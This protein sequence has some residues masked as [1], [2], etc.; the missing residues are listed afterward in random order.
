MSLHEK[1]DVRKIAQRVIF[2]AVVG[3]MHQNLIAQFLI[4]SPNYT[5][6]QDFGTSV[7]SAAGNNITS[8][9][10]NLTGWS[11]DAPLTAELNIVAAAPTNAGGRYAYTLN[12]VSDRKIGARPSGG[13]GIVKYGILFQNTSGQTINSFSV[14]YSGFQF[15]LGGNTNAATNTLTVDYKVSVAT[16]PMNA[17]GA[18]PMPSLNYIQTQFVAVANNGSQGNG[19]PGAVGSGVNSGC[20]SVAA[21]IPD[22]SYLLLRWTDVDDPQN[23]PH[24]GIDNIEVVFFT[25][26]TVINNTA[27]SFL[28]IELLDFSGIKSGNENLLNW[29][30]A[31]E[32][33]IIYHSIEKS[34]NG[35][36]FI[37]IAKFT[38]TLKDGLVK[39]YSLTDDS[40]FNDI[41]YYRLSTKEKDGS[42]K[43]YKTVSVETKAANNWNYKHYVNE[44]SLTVEFKNDVPPNGSIEL[45]DVSGKL[46]FTEKITESKTNISISLLNEGIYFVKLMTPQKTEYFKT[47][48]T[49]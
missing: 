37:E 36:D 14:S 19:Y 25:N 48:I 12:G 10:A 28:P 17:T 16:I 26:Q 41:T 3:L 33:N 38:P 44:E 4:A 35:L 34:N 23:D 20:I 2:I 18:T 15:S 43:H 32:S 11:Y 46:L 30:I 8:G 13:S 42:I 27:C 40:P 7:I 9:S 22:N 21:A 29:K 45:Y 1:I 31:G 47:I 6:T 24:L 5:Y 39:N 49:K